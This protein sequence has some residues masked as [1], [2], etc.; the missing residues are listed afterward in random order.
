MEKR[1]RAEELHHLDQLFMLI[2]LRLI[3]N[4]LTLFFLPLLLLFRMHAKRKMKKERIDANGYSAIA[5]AGLADCIVVFFC[6]FAKRD[7]WVHKLK[8][9]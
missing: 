6:A 2:H 3:L 8:L 4:L 1:T 7:F 5:L 9:N